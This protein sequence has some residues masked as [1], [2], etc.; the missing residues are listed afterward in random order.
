MRTMLTI[1]K[2]FAHIHTHGALDAVSYTELYLR[3]ISIML[4][5]LINRLYLV[6]PQ[7]QLSHRNLL[8]RVNITVSR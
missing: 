2:T 7:L 5:K 8:Q 1:H 3:N 6:F 4:A